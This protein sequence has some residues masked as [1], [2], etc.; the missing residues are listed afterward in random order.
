[1][2]R[3]VLGILAAIVL[4]AVGTF[5]LVSYV[6]SAKEQAEAGEPR[7][8]VYVLDRDVAANTPVARLTSAV[9]LRELPTAIVADGA[10]TDLGELAD[11]LITAVDLE[12]GEQLLTSRLVPEQSVT[13]S[14]VPEGLQELTIA[15]DPERAV[16]G[17]L[18]AGD[19][20]GVVISFDPFDLDV[21]EIE[22]GATG[23]PVGQS[24]GSDAGDDES[25]DSGETTADGPDKTPNMTHLTFHK[26]LVTAVQFDEQES[27]GTSDEDESSDAEPVERSPSHDLLVTLALPAPGVEQVVFAAEFGRIWLTLENADADEDGTR[28]VTLGEAYEDAEARP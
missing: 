21:A 26:V 8:E 15:L 13:R 25:G 24:D 12:A 1:M 10:V 4:A 20:V 28:I 27:L 23:V 7:T 16:G 18:A 19:T 11:D 6:Q 9:T 3:K 22:P 2:R 14:E 17:N 5:T